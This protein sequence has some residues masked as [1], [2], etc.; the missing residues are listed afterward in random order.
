MRRRPLKL[1]D[2]SFTSG[3]AKITVAIL[4]SA[5]M[6]VARTDRPWARKC[7]PGSPVWG[8]GRSPGNGFR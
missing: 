4:G 6:A 3:P 7:L 5:V 1:F 2:Q 8:D